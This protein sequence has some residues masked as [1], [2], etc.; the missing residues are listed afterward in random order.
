MR[1]LLLYTWEMFEPALLDGLSRNLVL[2]LLAKHPDW[3]RFAEVLQSGDGD[4]GTV[5]FKVP[6]PDTDQFL[7]IDT[8]D[9]EVTIGF[10][11]WHT[12]ESPWLE[13]PESDADTS[14]AQRSADLIE[15]ILNEDVVVVVVKSQEGRWAGSELVD[16]T[17]KLSPIRGHV[18]QVFSW[19]GTHDRVLQ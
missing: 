10:D 1:G 9:G 4:S 11:A 14:V 17:K 15:Q 18:V 19:L 3:D 13:D 6:R 8:G 12:H 2:R 16:A 7:W 5:R